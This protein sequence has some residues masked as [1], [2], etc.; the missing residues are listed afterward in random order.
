MV[1]KTAK[2]SILCNEFLKERMRT[3]MTT[4]EKYELLRCLLD[5]GEMLLESGAE[6]DRIEDTIVRMGAAYGAE[7]TDVFVIT[8][9][10]S[11]TLVF[12][13]GYTATE[14]RRVANEATTDFRRIESV[15]ALSRACCMDPLP[16][17][18]LR[19]RVRQVGEG[20]KS[21]V[22]TLIGSILAAAGFAVFFG[23]SIADGAA[24]ALFASVIAAA[25]KQLSTTKIKTIEGNLIISLFLGLAAGILTIIIPSLHMDKILIGDIMLLIPGI[26]MTNAIRNMLVGDT[27]SGIVRLAESLM[28]A[29]AIAGGIMVALAM[30]NFV[31]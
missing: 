23:G 31:H 6:I 24:A 8:S 14:T 13:D 5:M 10:I 15:N 28:W 20:H 9:I 3:E 11:I 21:Y 1:E 12:G 29:V 22:A 19:K 17:H 16:V 30:I 27:I 18:A 4:E 26:A 25:Q 7:R 2:R